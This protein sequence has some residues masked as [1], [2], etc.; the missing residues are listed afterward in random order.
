MPWP[1][2]SPSAMDAI[3]GWCGEGAR[4]ACGLCS[5]PAICCASLGGRGSRSISA[6]SMSSCSRLTP[7]AFSTIPRRSPRS[8]PWRDWRGCCRSA[9]RIPSFMPPRSTS[10]APS[11]M[12]SVWPALF[13]R[14]ELQLLGELGFGLDLSECAATGTDADLVYVS[15][16]SG[17][18]VSRDA[19]KPYC[20]RL[21]KLPAFLLDATA[22]A[23]EGDILAGLRSDRPLPRARRA[24]AAWPL[25]AAGARAAHSDPRSASQVGC[26]LTHLPWLPTSR[27]SRALTK[28]TD[29]LSAGHGKEDSA[30]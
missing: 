12:P 5:S 24:R 10:C 6:A 29:A 8:A 11:R 9:I 21:L 26:R 27:S 28:S 4:A 14:W 22:P 23:D 16:R 20:D 3:S 19:G 7:R 2:C 18:A 13:V 30:A 25:H 1:S 17:R 15:P